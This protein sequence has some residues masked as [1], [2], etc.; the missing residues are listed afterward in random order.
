MLTIPPDSRVWPALEAVFP[1]M[2]DALFHAFG[3][4]GW[5]LLMTDGSFMNT[6]ARPSDAS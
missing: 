4:F 5:H 1:R 2:P 3:R 6:A